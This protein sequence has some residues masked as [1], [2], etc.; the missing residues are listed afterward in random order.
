MYF[1]GRWGIPVPRRVAITVLVAATATTK[2]AAP[3]RE[4]VDA[5]HE[6]VYGNLKRAFDAQKAFAGYPARELVVR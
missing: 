2:T 3:S 5:L 4:A 1:Y 6:E